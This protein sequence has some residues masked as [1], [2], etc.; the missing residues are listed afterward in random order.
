[1]PVM[2]ARATAAGRSV[3]CCGKLADQEYG[4]DQNQ[5]QDDH[6]VQ[7]VPEDANG[8]IAVRGAERGLQQND[9]WDGDGE[10]PQGGPPGVFDRLRDRCSNSPTS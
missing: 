8:A 5:K 3:G 2:T 7:D 1:M 6:G 4:H 9:G 10:R